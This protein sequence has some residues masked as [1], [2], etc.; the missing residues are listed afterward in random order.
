[1][2]APQ[3]IQRPQRRT[4]FFTYSSLLASIASGANGAGSFTVD[5]D[6]DFELMKLTY[7]ADV[8][9]G[10]ETHD[11]AVVPLVTVQITEGGASGFQW[12]NQALPIPALFGTAEVPFILPQP[13]LILAGQTVNLA[14][15]NIS[16]A[17]T[18]RLYLAFIGRKIFK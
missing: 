10:A 4:A 12:Q 14:F 6:A 5:Q 7:F 18:Y 13:R 11:T 1:M 9:G 16:S 17:T 15:L 3:V 2:P 8:A